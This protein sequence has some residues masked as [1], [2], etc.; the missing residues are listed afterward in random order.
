MLSLMSADRMNLPSFFSCS[1]LT[2][3]RRFRARSNRF[4]ATS[5]SCL[6]LALSSSTFV[7]S[8]STFRPS[9]RPLARSLSA[10]ASANCSAI[11]VSRWSRAQTP[12]T[13]LR[14][15]SATPRC[16]GCRS[17]AGVS[18]HGDAIARSISLDESESS[19]TLS[20]AARTSSRSD[21]LSTSTTT[22]AGAS[23]GVLTLKG[24]GRAPAFV[25][26]L[27]AVGA[28]VCVAADLS[29]GTL[30]GL[31]NVCAV[32]AGLARARLDGSSSVPS[33]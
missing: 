11:F 13:A 22:A 5:A 21:L 29:K 20:R 25:D 17:E 32:A 31:G 24:L 28:G 7:R 30:K 19:G 23:V 1:S 15:I 18:R 33:G 3:L 2:V 10:A 26:V 27:A 12:S 16:I 14:S 4:A 6:A 9:K 8:P